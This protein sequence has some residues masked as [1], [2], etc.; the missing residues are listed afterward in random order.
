MH[1]PTRKAVLK[2]VLKSCAK[3][4]ECLIYPSIPGRK[5]YP[6]IYVREMGATGHAHRL[7][8]FL[9]HGFIP[10]GMCVMHKCDNRR[11]VN[12]IHL[13][14]GTNCDN[15]RDMRK[16]GRGFQLP[17]GEQS[18]VAK[19][20]D[21]DI[22]E[23]RSAASAGRSYSE[24]AR[25]FRIHPSHVSRVARSMTRKSAGGAIIRR[26]RRVPISPA[27]AKRIRRMRQ[28]GKTWVSIAMIMKLSRTAVMRAAG[29]GVA[30]R[31]CDGKAVVGCRT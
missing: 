20:T 25:R 24:M 13:S 9:L 21:Q 28:N 2:S 14:L 18:Y 30:G 10:V 11:C 27:Q 19:L 12:P 26:L 5:G 16:K 22:R 23:I 31:N 29:S 6:R 4:G 8:W 1:V 17:S 15:Q 3:Q 7:V